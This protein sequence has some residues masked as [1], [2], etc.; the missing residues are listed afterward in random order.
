MDVSVTFTG[1][2]PLWLGLVLATAGAVGAWVLY[3]RETRRGRGVSRWLLP[4]LRA[5]AIFLLA[6]V[7][8][9]PVLSRRRTVER[10]SRLLVFLDGS[11]SMSV[12]DRYEA[13][14]LKLRI[15]RVRGWL[16][17]EALDTS[18]VETADALAE[19]AQATAPGRRPG[20]PVTVL[21][22]ACLDFSDRTAGIHERLVA[23][24]PADLAGRFRADVVKPADAL[25]RRAI[26]KSNQIE[27]RGRLR[28]LVRSAERFEAELRSHFAAYAEKRVRSG[29]PEI[30]AALEKLDGMSRWR[31]AEAFLLGSDRGVLRALAA[32]HD[33]QLLVLPNRLEDE[34]AVLWGAAGGDDAPS[35]LPDPPNGAST[36]L[37]RGVERRVDTASVV[38]PSL[39]ALEAPADGRSA[40]TAVVLVSD[41]RHN[42]AG[43][44]IE[45]ARLLGARGVPVYTIGL[46]GAEPRPDLAIAAVRH[47]EVLYRDDTVRGQIELRDHMPPG[48]PFTLRVEHEGQVVWEQSLTTTGGG[49]RRVELTFSIRDVVQE[50][51]AAMASEGLKAAALP[52]SM[53]VRLTPQAGE[54]RQSN[55]RR[56]LHVVKSL[57][58]D[59]RVMI[60][61]GR[62]RWETRYLRNLFERDPRWKVN[63]L[64]AATRGDLR[65]GEGAGQFPAERASLLGY[66]LI[67]LGDLPAGVL[68]EKQIGWIVEF[69]EAR[70][71]GVIFLDGRRGHL[72]SLAATALGK[73]LPVHWPEG[74]SP[75][76]QRLQLTAA[77]AAEP[78]LSLTGDPARDEEF[79]R[80]LPAPHWAARVTAAPSAETLVEAVDNTGGRPAVVLGRSG[81]GR[82]LYCGFDESWRWRRNVADEYHLRYWNQL[83]NAV[84]ERPFAA[85][86]QYVSIDTRQMVYEA[87]QS[88][89]IRVRLRDE[90]GKPILQAPA[91]AVL[92]KDDE[93][94]AGAALE[95]DRDSG[96]V[97][98]AA[99][100][101]LGEGRYAIRVRAENI[102]P[103]RMQAQLEFTVLPPGAREMDRLEANPS[104]LRQMAEQ[105]GGAFLPE[106]KA[107]ELPHML[108]AF[109]GRQEVETQTVLWQSYWWFAPIV[110][111]LAVELLLRKRSGLL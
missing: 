75:P 3:R 15:A 107:H 47:T 86:D 19:T 57:P 64:I 8:T 32:D 89:D 49:A 12:D 69:V 105:S 82:V 7:L 14:A 43:S 5:T 79:W 106:E 51:L 29:D 2:A 25:A 53:T 20:A 16:S 88:A 46:G 108:K 6:M 56:P 17:P 101:P 18:P 95:A 62:P 54:D 23:S 94:I 42:G 85:E 96:G 80:S 90:R 99:T 66:D 31:R 44:P 83:A 52:L 81:A 74:G 26:E 70:G 93:E 27:V 65:T 102:P 22:Q 30:A 36:D 1:D 13:T 87:G 39:G 92:M 78:I 60:L 24:A 111:L 61:D 35:Q 11:A 110:G 10:P 98:R 72:R 58:R 4:L 103:G 76:P 40:R 77:G 55:N 50:K 91:Q 84:R 68:S 59:A 38:A 100:G 33:V 73:L 71:G 104:L 21:R 45:T 67:V 41:G 48:R 109:A 9:G 97:F 28:E 37:T 34:A 63:T